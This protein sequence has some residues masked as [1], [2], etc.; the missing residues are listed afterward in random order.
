MKMK[1]RVIDKRIRRIYDN[2]KHQYRSVSYKR[3]QLENKKTNVLIYKKKT[4]YEKQKTG[5]NR[6][7]AHNLRQAHKEY[8]L[9]NNV[10]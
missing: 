10:C 2:D 7:Y 1:Y 3:T 4:I 8:H 9:I 5:D 6:L